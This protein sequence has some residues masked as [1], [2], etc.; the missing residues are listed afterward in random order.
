M[1]RIMIESIII[2]V[3]MLEDAWFRLYKRMCNNVNQSF[4]L[5]ASWVQG[6]VCQNIHLLNSCFL[7]FHLL[8]K[9]E[10]SLVI[11]QVSPQQDLLHQE[12]Q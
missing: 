1:F 4:F 11:D 9:D 2:P 6:D 8:V 7:Q 12:Q 3:I 10:G 5:K